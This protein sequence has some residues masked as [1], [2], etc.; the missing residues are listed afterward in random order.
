MSEYFYSTIK[1]DEHLLN[2]EKILFKISKINS[3]FKEP[4][5]SISN[6]DWNLK[7]DD[8]FNF[9]F[10]K[11]DQSKII[12][13]IFQKRKGVLSIPNAWFNQYYPK[14]GSTHP[15]H[16]HEEVDFIGIYYVELQDPCLT[17]VLIDPIT[18]KEVRP[19]INEGD[20][21]IC[22]G[23]IFHMSP[24]NHTDSRKTVISFNFQFK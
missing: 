14:S 18:K 20:M 23:D 22:S 21:L 11:T 5:Y 19:R 1:I 10:S 3:Q 12:N 15:F 9:S 8:W 13:K 16:I 2:K 7:R 17:T 4:S 24:P 6:T